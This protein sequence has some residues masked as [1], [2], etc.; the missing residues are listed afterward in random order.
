M[1]SPKVGMPSINVIAG[2]LASMSTLGMTTLV[3]VAIIEANCGPCWHVDRGS[4]KRQVKNLD[5][6]APWWPKANLLESG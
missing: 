6:R 5:L 2:I 4:T 3:K 1:N